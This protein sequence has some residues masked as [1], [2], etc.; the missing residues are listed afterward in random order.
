MQATFGNDNYLPNSF[1]SVGIAVQYFQ[2]VKVARA[3]SF[4]LE[5]VRNELHSQ[6][7]FHA[8]EPFLHQPVGVETWVVVAR[9]DATIAPVHSL[10]CMEKK[11]EKKKKKKEGTGSHA[12]MRALT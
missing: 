7:R 8:D 11:R 5:G 2:P 4:N 6:T 10:N 9:Y 3:L 1:A 12:R